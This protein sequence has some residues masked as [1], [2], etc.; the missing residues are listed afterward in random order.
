[1]DNDFDGALGRAMQQSV[2]EDKA[3]DA[4]RAVKVLTTM[5]EELTT[6]VTRLETAVDLLKKTR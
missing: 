5:V 1:M 6:R 4:Q 2:A 3:K